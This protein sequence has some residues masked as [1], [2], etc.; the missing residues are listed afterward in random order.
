MSEH[1]ALQ[2]L[3]HRQKMWNGKR[4]VKLTR[5]KSTREL[6]IEKNQ[7]FGVVMASVSGSPGKREAILLE[8]SHLMLQKILPF[9]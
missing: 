9:L 3:Q 2:G 8:K 1:S 4:G 6:G 5:T 7:V